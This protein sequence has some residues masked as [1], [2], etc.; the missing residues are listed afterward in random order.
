[1]SN[2]IVSVV[3]VSYKLLTGSEN[4][5]KTVAIAI[6]K[7]HQRLELNIE[8]SNMHQVNEFVHLDQTRFNDVK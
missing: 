2:A 1:M 4:V 7:I 5:Q 8:E 6:V 3:T